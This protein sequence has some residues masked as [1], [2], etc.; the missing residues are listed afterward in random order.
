MAIST[1]STSSSSA[2][3]DEVVLRTTETTRLI[4][5]PMIIENPH[6]P[7]ASVKGWFIFQKKKKSGNW[8]DYN[9]FPLN[10]LKDGE[11]VKLE[12]KSAEI[13]KLLDHLPK[14]RVIFKNYGIRWGES[15]FHIT[16]EH[17]PDVILQLSKL[18]NKDFNIEALKN[19]SDEDIKNFYRN[20]LFHLEM[21]KKRR[22][23]DQFE[24]QLEQNLNEFEWQRWFKENSWILGTEFIRILNERRIDRDHISDYLMEAYDGFLDIVEIKKPARDLEFWAHK[25]DRENFIPSTH[26]IK[27]IT[28]VTKYIY[29]VEREA[30]SIKFQNQI[31]AVKIIKPRCTLIFGRSDRWTTEHR[32]SYRILNSSYHHLTILTY[33]HVLDRAKSILSVPKHQ[34]DDKK[35]S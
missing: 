35:E 12:L 27:A 16:D 23:I 20:F 18:E 26:L 25:K 30:N 9:H 31:G 13:K 14:L 11:W 15:H 10:K 21:D 34:S 28:Q 3:A 1:K 24:Q 7:E 29:E 4:F 22:A 17:I 19:L 32:E 8:E 6:D 33:D 5:K 2:E